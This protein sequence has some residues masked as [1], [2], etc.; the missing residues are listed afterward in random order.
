MDLNSTMYIILK[1]TF[2]V[3]SFPYIAKLKEGLFLSNC[4]CFTINTKP[5]IKFKQ[6]KESVVK[7]W[8]NKLSAQC[9]KK[10]EYRLTENFRY[11]KTIIRWRWNI[12]RGKPK[13]LEF[14]L[15]L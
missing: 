3:I 2:I 5:L 12:R 9:L 15:L 8:Q 10:V 14:F 6:K 1:V 7:Y 4:L 13:L 11:I